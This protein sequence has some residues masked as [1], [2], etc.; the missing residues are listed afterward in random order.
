MDKVVERTIGIFGMM[1]SREAAEAARQRLTEYLRMI[2]SAGESDPERLVVC[3]LTYLREQEPE[4]DP[5][6]RG[7]SGL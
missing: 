1:R 3:G 2:S 6:P 7:Y 4:N 5:L